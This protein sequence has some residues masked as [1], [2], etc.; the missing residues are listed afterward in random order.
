M[1]YEIHCKKFG[2]EDKIVS[3]GADC[4]TIE[5]VLEFVKELMRDYNIVRIVNMS[6][7]ATKPSTKKNE[8]WLRPTPFIRE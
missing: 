8:I 2:G 5:A 7:T 1:P 6:D 4:C 3:I